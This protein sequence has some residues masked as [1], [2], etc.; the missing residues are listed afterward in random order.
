MHHCDP[1]SQQ[2]TGA[3]NC[4]HLSQAPRRVVCTGYGN[5][6]AEAELCGVWAAVTYPAAQIRTIAF[7]A[8]VVSV[9]C[10][11]CLASQERPCCLGLESDRHAITLW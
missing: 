3:D 4:V 1:K 11:M 10:D 9:K 8:P 7:G 6:G 5:G 2:C